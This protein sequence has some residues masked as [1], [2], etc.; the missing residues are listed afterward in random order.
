VPRSQRI[1][2]DETPRYRFERSDVFTVLLLVGWCAL[3]IVK[4]SHDVRE[5]RAQ[6]AAIAAFA[7]RYPAETLHLFP[8]AGTPVAKI[9]YVPGSERW[10]L[11]EVVGYLLTL[12][13]LAAGSGRARRRRVS[14]EVKW[15]RSAE[16]RSATGRQARPLSP[17][18]AAPGNVAA[19]RLSAIVWNDRVVR[20]EKEPA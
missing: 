6:Q 2:K 1:A 12:V 17:P 14:L 10:L 15:L 4:I 5:Y 19:D 7:T 8:D 11:G 20:R 3:G 18:S 9:P 16:R 13:V